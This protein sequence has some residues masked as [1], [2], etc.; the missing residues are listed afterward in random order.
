MAARVVT[1]EGGGAVK[2]FE[3]QQ[4]EGKG[5]EKEKQK[6]WRGD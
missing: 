6:E 3:K 5:K 4:E 2:D 1:G